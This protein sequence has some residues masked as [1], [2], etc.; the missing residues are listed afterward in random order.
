MAHDAEEIGMTLIAK[1]SVHHSKI[2]EA[3]IA[4]GILIASVVLFMGFSGLL[5]VPGSHR[6]FSITLLAIAAGL[7]LA[8][9]RV[10][11]LSHHLSFGAALVQVST[12]VLVG[13]VLTSFAV[14]RGNW[15]ETMKELAQRI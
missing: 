2:I 11:S 8:M 15:L 5:F 1:Y 14:M 3:S 7:D 13:A 10:R 12:A 9:A 6:V 4:V